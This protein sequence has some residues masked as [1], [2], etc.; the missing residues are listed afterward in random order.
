MT[1]FIVLV[2]ILFVIS[3][4]L[5]AAMM[6]VNG[7]NLFNFSDTRAQVMLAVALVV[8]LYVAFRI[9]MIIAARDNPKDPDSPLR[10][11]QKSKLL[12]VFGPKK[13]AALQAREARVA[14]RREKLVREGKLEAEEVP[15]AADTT[16]EA[17]VRVSASASIKDKMAAREERVRRAR[18]AGKLD[19]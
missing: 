5:M 17:P 14:A 1:R 13:S 16:G 7:L 15:E 19:D 11:A 2:S 6:A 4:G 8:A 3:V 12:G 10:G 9:S 18:E